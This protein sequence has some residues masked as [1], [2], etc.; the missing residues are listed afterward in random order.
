MSGA[1][2]PD[3][4]QAMAA[5]GPT[6]LAYRNFDGKDSSPSGSARWSF[7]TTFPLLADALPEIAAQLVNPAADNMAAKPMH[8]E[9]LPPLAAEQRSGFDSIPVPPMAP[10]SS[11][12]ISPATEGTIAPLKRSPLQQTGTA[13]AAVFG[14]LR[15]QTP[16]QQVGTK[17]GLNDLFRRL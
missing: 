1:S 11:E 4:K 3:I 10:S 16:V 9:P 14:L 5:I 17:P 13:L 8:S 12:A 15:G 7:A 2:D 6:A